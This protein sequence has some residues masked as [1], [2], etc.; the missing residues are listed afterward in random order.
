[1]LNPQK[2]FA[3]ENQIVPYINIYFPSLSEKQ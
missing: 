1:M 3:E 2:C